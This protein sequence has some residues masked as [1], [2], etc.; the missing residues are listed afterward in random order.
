MIYNKDDMDDRKTL[1]FIGAHPDDESFG[2]G[3]TL[4]KYALA[5]VKVYY[6]VATRGEAGEVNPSL[7]A[8]FTS[9]GDLR[10]SELQCAAKVLGLTGVIWLGYRDSGMRGSPDN[11]HPQALMNA[12]LD[13][14]AGRIVKI[15]RELKP[16]VVITFDPMG[17]YNHPDHVAVHQATVKAFYAAGDA[18]QYPDNGESF[19]PQKL[20]FSIFPWG[21]LKITV[22]LMPLW[23]QDPHRLGKNQDI[24]LASVAS[25]NYP[26]HAIVRLNKQALELKDKAT[27]CHASQ[28]GE[29]RPRRGWLFALADK[30]IRRRDLFMRAYPP[31]KS[32]RKEKDLFAGLE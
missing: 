9:L 11:A 7:M 14:V 22:K 20:Y 12:P 4:A 25:V 32:R 15:L 27:A 31:V 21:L 3:G 16:Q 24:D 28:L 17:G 5:G 10:W 13:E 23:G 26:V 1:V 30:F 19:Q 6:I 18:G 29:G 2:I 8:N